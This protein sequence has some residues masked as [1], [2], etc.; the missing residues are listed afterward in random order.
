[1]SDY[2]YIVIIIITIIAILLFKMEGT[3]NLNTYHD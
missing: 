2:Y 1:M 3:F